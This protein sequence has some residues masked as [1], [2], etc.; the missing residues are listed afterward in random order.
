MGGSV[1]LRA[2]SGGFGGSG[3]VV[4]RVRGF[5]RFRF[6]WEGKVIWVWG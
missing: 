1:G 5:F 2:R 4:R 3:G 6:F